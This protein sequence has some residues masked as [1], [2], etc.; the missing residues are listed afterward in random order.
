MDG[1]SPEHGRV[2]GNGVSVPAAHA[3]VGSIRAR[4]GRG[5]SGSAC[6]VWGRHS[7]PRVY[8]RSDVSGW[9]SEYTGHHGKWKR[10]TEG[11]SPRR[12]MEARCAAAGVGIV[13]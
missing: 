10:D 12:I 4:V 9:N 11:S 3:G 6:N 8:R 2:Y 7:H 5:W 13:L 1:G